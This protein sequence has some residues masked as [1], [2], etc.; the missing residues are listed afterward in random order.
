MSDEC[1]FF[2][3][4]SRRRHTRCA[5][6]TGVQTCALPIWSG[7]TDTVVELGLRHDIPA[8]DWAWGGDLE[9]SHY[10]PNYRRNQT[11]KVWEGPVWASLFV[12][13]KDV[14]G[15]TARAQIS[16]MVNARSKRD[17]IVYTGARGDSPVSFIEQ[18]DRLIGPIFAFSLRGDR[19]SGV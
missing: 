4:S 12:E 19:K 16:N 18:R 1:V 9:Y 17:R 11:D 6:V 10:Q 14:F 3:F 7:F 15:L 5:L 8:S 13:N 2:F